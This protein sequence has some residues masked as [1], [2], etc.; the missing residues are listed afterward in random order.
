MIEF[1]YM[2]LNEKDRKFYDG[3]T[4]AQQKTYQKNWI[5]VEKQKEKTNQAKARLNKMKK[6][7]S[8]KE[9]KARTRHLI[10]VGGVVEKYVQIS[11]LE[12]FEAY[13]KQYTGAIQRTQKAPIAETSAV[14]PE[15]SE[16]THSFL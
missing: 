4:E 5:A 16:A 1:D 10:E 2:K 15:T 6:A 13:I 11:N 3:L 12:S 8:D 14:E 9:R 7:Q